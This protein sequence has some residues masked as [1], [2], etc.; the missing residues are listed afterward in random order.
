M[1]KKII[2]FEASGELKERLRFLAFAQDITVSALIRNLLEDAVFSNKD[3][4]AND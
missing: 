2:S 1:T 3:L 4:T